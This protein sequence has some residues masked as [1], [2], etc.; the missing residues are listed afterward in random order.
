VG[1]IVIPRAIADAPTLPARADVACRH[2]PVHTVVRLM[3]PPQ[4]S[5]DKFF[6]PAPPHI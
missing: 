2:L 6:A 4:P 5:T 3:D 1:R